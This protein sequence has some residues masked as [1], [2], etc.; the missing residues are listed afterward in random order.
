MGVIFLSDRV[1]TLQTGINGRKH[2]QDVR[3][4]VDALVFT[5]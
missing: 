5:R 2:K 1:T 3:F 4:L